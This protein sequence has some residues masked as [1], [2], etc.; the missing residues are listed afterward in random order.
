MM[1]WQELVA[2]VGGELVENESGLLIPAYRTVVFTVERQNGK[3]TLI[4]GWEV[5]RAIG[6]EDYGPQNISYSAQTGNDAR[7]KLLDDQVPV[8]ERHRALLDIRTVNRSNGNEGVVW[9]NGSRLSLMA[10]TAEA[11]HGKTIDL[12]V[13]DELF[14]DDDDRR[15]QAL[16]PA[17]ATRPAAQVVACSTMGTEESVP[18]NALVERGR[19]SVEKGSRSGI[20]YFEWSIPESEDIDDPANWWRYMPAMGRTISEDVIRDARETMTEGDF[21]RAFCNQQTKADDRVF[22]AQVWDRVCDP[23]AAPAGDLVF[24]LDVNP[25]RSAASIAVASGDE[26][27][28]VEVVDHRPG[29]GWVLDRASELSARWGYPLWMVDASGPAASLIGD[30]ERAGVEV[31]ALQSRDVAAACGRFFDDVLEVNVSVR[32]AAVLDAAVA[33]AVKHHRGDAWVWAR[34]DAAA[35]VSPLVAVTLAVH[36][37]RNAMSVPLVAWR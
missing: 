13:K 23:S 9:R 20:A 7:K 1:P 32:R 37:A 11:G 19:R 10:S 28:V 25:E 4:L 31:V 3:T 18:W 16:I 35:D 14:A 6:W 27:P 2:N 36:G 8:L 12:G 15:D 34:K 17:M 29:I 26:K 22:P 24:A 5:Q 21:R 30:L 33:A